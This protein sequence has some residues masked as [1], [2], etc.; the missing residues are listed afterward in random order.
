MLRYEAR[1]TATPEQVWPL[2]ARPS[3]WS[4]WAPHLR[5]AWGLGGEEVRPGAFGAVRLLGVVPVPARI[6]A[7]DPGRSWDWQVGPASF[8]HRVE[9]AP[10]GSLVGVDISVP[11]PLEPLLRVAY[12]PLVALLVRNLARV[13]GRSG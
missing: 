11:G 6:T 7:K 9:P 8:R 10:G 13:A 12:G 3:R 2:L 5:R 1:T 4:A